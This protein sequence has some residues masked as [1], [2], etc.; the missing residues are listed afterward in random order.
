ML[1]IHRKALRCLLLPLRPSS[2][3]SIIVCHITLYSYKTQ[4]KKNNKSLISSIQDHNY[5]YL[6][7]AGCS[8]E[9]MAL[10][11]PIKASQWN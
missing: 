7:R 8:V 3:V 10:L 6:R 9:D 4:I 5:R 1:N 2:P 11:I